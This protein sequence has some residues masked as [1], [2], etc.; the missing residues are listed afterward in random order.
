MDCDWTGR[1]TLVTG[2]SLNL[3]GEISVDTGLTDLLA[4]APVAAGSCRE[5]LIDPPG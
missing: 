4:R 2:L 1:R 3:S 5:G